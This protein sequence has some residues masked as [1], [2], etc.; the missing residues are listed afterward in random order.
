M[1]EFMVGMIVGALIF[2]VVVAIS[3]AKAAKDIDE[4]ETEIF[5][6]EVDKHDMEL[7]DNLL[8]P[9]ATFER[10]VYTFCESC[11]DSA[12]EEARFEPLD[13]WTL[14]D[15][16]YDKIKYEVSDD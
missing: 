11:I 6:K 2:S 10:M 7:I 15:I 4:T 9:R 16:A 14:A 8:N 3:M 12:R 1:N 5:A 13:E